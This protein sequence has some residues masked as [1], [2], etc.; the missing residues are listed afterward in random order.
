MRKRAR[1]D[2]R[3]KE[4]RDLVKRLRGKYK[5]KGWLRELEQEKRRE[6]ELEE[7]RARPCGENPPDS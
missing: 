3:D 7:K 4:F 1:K 5:G 2:T 6:I